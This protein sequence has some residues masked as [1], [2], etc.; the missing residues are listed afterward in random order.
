MN[1]NI[2]KNIFIGNI[3]FE[4]NYDNIEEVLEVNKL[5]NMI[6]Y[7]A[8]GHE[9]ANLDC[10]LY[11]SE[12]RYKEYIQSDIKLL[13][14]GKDEDRLL[15]LDHKYLF[16]LNE[17]NLG[18][19]ANVNK[20]D[21]GDVISRVSLYFDYLKRMIDKKTFNYLTELI[22]QQRS[23]GLPNIEV[24][25]IDEEEAREYIKDNNILKPII[26]LNT[27]YEV[28]YINKLKVPKYIIDNCVLALKTRF[29]VIQVSRY[30]DKNRYIDRMID[31]LDQSKLVKGLLNHMVGSISVD[32]YMAGIVSRFKKSKNVVI[33]TNRNNRMYGYLDNDNVNSKCNIGN[34]LK[35]NKPRTIKINNKIYTESFE[36][37]CNYSCL[38]IKESDILK[39]FGYSV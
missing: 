31:V 2:N 29:E 9:F 7:I 35:C 36:C 5:S 26:L 3:I 33:Y 4:L 17:L 38:A 1:K 25:R 34:Q 22:V 23:L 37:K 15:K 18:F 27:D 20:K 13:I 6:L 10:Y 12:P 8:N 16:K 11:T 19:T 32:N 24:S 21:Q 30:K 14:K 39:K 28:D